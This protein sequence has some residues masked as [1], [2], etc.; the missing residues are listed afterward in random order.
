MASSDEAFCLK[1][2]D[3]QESI[4]SSLGGLL[5]CSDLQDVTLQCGQQSLQCHRLVLAACSDWFRQI[6]KTVNSTNNK[7]PV[8]V[9]WDA[10]ARDMEMLLNFMYNGVVNVKQEH[11]NSF[12]ALAE[13]LSV[14]GLTQ[15]QT[16]KQDNTVS[17]FPPK[18][19]EVSAPSQNHSHHSLS[20]QRSRS[21]TT[22]S[23]AVQHQEADIQEV[24]VVKQEQGMKEDYLDPGDGAG[25]MVQ[26]EGDGDVGAYDD[27]YY[28]DPSAAV[29]EFDNSANILNSKGY[30]KQT[31]G[32][33]PYCHKQ[34]QNI[35][36]HIEDKHIPNPTPCT[37][38]GKVF[39]SI[40]K[41]RA[42]RSYYHR[43]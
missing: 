24:A 39:N 20:Q 1:W 9:L 19:S 21:I 36:Y 42:H 4:S 43:R 6:F 35:S 23:S 14:R 11:L 8:I 26:Y 31:P 16:E 34:V 32:I 37:V 41:M 7:H 38:C 40:N 12:L 2:N 18:Q 30:N 10:A 28:E 33:C 27:N 22:S 13:R 3:F 5:H 15:N 25:E 29:M 17:R